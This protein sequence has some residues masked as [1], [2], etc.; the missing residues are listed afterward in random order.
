MNILMLKVDGP[1]TG[2]EM[3]GKQLY[4]SANL[5]LKRD[6]HLLEPE[7]DFLR[8]RPAR[9]IRYE[10]DLDVDLL[11]QIDETDRSKLNVQQ[12]AVYNTVIASVDN[13]RNMLISLDAC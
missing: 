2:T 6:F 8:S 3:T 10:N 4:K 7:T 1:A 11:R 12:L 9:A 13:S 5:Q